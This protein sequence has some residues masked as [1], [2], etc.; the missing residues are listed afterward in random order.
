MHKGQGA[1]ERLQRLRTL[2]TSE[3][4]SALRHPR[5]IGAWVEP[6]SAWLAKRI[7]GAASN[8]LDPFT[9]G[10]GFRV[11]ALEEERAVL[12][13]PFT[14][15]TRGEGAVV[16]HGALLSLAELTAKIFWQHHLDLRAAEVVTT[17]INVTMIRPAD[18]DL[19]AVFYLP[20]NEREE[21]LRQLRI[22]GEVET[23]SNITVYDDHE[24]L[25][26]EVVVDWR[27]ARRPALQAKGR[28]NES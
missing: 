10:V 6:H 26:A 25:V 11:V 7:V 18:S 28:E 15:R 8:I 13:M 20:E 23:K 12:E 4:A 24:R 14:W 22:T 17:Q 19:R 5:S 16:H 9:A 1:R 2:V 3:F 21:V 27:F